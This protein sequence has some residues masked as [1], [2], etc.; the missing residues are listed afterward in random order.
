[1]RQQLTLA[2]VRDNPDPKL[3]SNDVLHKYHINIEKQIDVYPRSLHLLDDTITFICRDEHGKHFGI[4]APDK[5]CTIMQQFSGTE[6]IL[7][8]KTWLK[9]CPMEQAN[10]EVLR[11][12]FDFTEPQ[13]IGVCNSFGF[14]D[15]LG[16]ANP[17]H[18][19]SVAKTGI[20]PVLAQQSI[21]ELDRTERTP[22]E[23]MDAA[24][25]AVFQ[26]GY[27]NGF[28][29]DADHLKTTEDIDRMVAAGFTMFTLDPDDHLEQAADTFSGKK[30]REYAGKLPWDKLQDSP[31]KCIDRYTSKPIHVS[32]NL[33][34]DVTDEEVFRAMVKYG[35]VLNFTLRMQNHLVNQ[36]PDHPREIELSVD[37]SDSVTQ[38]FE[39][40]FVVNEL[41]RLGVEL[42]SFAP[43]FVGGFEKGIDYKGDIE[44]FRKH[45]IQHVDI[46]ESMGPYKLSIHSGSDKFR[47][48]ET[49]GS[50][51]QGAVH[52]KTAGTSYL[53]ALKT[54]GAVAPDFLREI[55]DYSREQYEAEKKTYHVSARL[56][57]VPSGEN[58]SDSALIKLF[59]ND[60]ARQVFH[61][62]YGKVLTEK[63][64][65]QYR[66]RNK[67]MVLLDAK[68]SEHYKNLRLHF[69]RHLK[70][71]TRK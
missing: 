33:T 1:M 30:L 27:H 63:D 4:V 21:R 47:V 54:I 59:E 36:Y 62:S 32:D 5:T 64:G 18:L 45:Y 67:I 26:E 70:P 16:L 42:V 8:D 66:F 43:R 50:L 3:V 49:I 14:G 41:K 48:Y 34:F 56:D 61:V 65:M 58:C 24:S 38:P 11:D 68:E 51:G 57:N 10:A 71:F 2:A 31:E 9:L 39:H 29:A 17:G 44:Q 35:P 13:L 23:V 53:E 37:E 55:L 7:P 12:Y 40:Y 69:D 46:A 20:R 19:R 25:W 52:V 6:L 60:D 15:R 28:G 22:E